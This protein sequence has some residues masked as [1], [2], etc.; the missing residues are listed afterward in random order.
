MNKA[1]S[2]KE[3]YREGYPYCITYSRTMLVPDKNFTSQDQ[4]IKS[5]IATVGCDCKYII[6]PKTIAFCF[7]KDDY[8]YVNQNSIN[9]RL[10]KTVLHY[11]QLHEIRKY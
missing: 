8:D 7:K 5:I 3:A 2:I 10:S 11:M 1:T 6:N 4:L 9:N